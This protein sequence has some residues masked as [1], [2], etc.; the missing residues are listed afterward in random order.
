[1]C[2]HFPSRF[3]CMKKNE[4]GGKKSLEMQNESQITRYT[5]ADSICWV[6]LFSSQSWLDL[7]DTPGLGHLLAADL[8]SVYN[9][10][11]EQ[12]WHFSYMM[13]LTNCVSVCVSL[14]HQSKRGRILSI[15]QTG[16]FISIKRGVYNW[17]PVSEQ[18]HLPHWASRTLFILNVFLK[19]NNQQLYLMKFNMR[20]KGQAL[21]S[22]SFP[23]K[24]SRVMSCHRRDAFHL[25]P[26]S[27]PWPQIPI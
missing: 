23:P 15:L 21:C 4:K 22:L 5:F 1:M 25:Q 2:Q 13:S 17:T 27:N 10:Y 7:Q 16:I 3:L 9:G 19:G 12:N 11:R 18:E 14:K 6:A 24:R 20:S 26:T 8:V